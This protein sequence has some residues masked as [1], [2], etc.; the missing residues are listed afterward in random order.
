M[1][2]GQEN[3]EDAEDTADQGQGASI[4]PGVRLNQSSLTSTQM[5]SNT[6]PSINTTAALGYWK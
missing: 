1:I 2:I 6:N 3:Q 5:A 4:S